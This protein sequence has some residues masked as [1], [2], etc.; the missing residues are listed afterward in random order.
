M[1]EEAV[2]FQ[3]PDQD[4]FEHMKGKIL[5]DIIKQYMGMHGCRKNFQ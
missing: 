5:D 3:P 4:K 2:I 1:K